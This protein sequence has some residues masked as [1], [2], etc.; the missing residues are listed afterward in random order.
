MALE[1]SLV[2]QKLLCIFKGLLIT[3]MKYKAH[4]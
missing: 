4:L 1:V 2:D 3:V